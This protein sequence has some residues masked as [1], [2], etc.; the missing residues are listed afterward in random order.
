MGTAVLLTGVKYVA[1]WKARGYSV[2]AWHAPVGAWILARGVYGLQ[3][4]I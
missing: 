2:L 4:A 1:G 3:I